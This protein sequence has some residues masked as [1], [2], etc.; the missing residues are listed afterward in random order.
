MADFFQLGF[1]HCKKNIG[2][3]FAT[4]ATK[5]GTPFAKEIL[6]QTATIPDVPI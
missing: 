2:T 1:F 5:V 6:E 4:F 3:P